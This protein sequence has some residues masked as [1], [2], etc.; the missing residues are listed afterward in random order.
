MP[1]ALD[2]AGVVLMIEPMERLDKLL[3]TGKKLGFER[4]MLK[5]KL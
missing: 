1:W 4:R 5:L 3:E 2:P